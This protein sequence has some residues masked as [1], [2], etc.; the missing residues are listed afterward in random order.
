MKDTDIFLKVNKNYFGLNLKSIDILMIAQIEEFRRNNCECYVTNEQFSTMFGESESTIKR[1]IDKLEKLNII[2]RSTKFINGNGKGTKQ[3]ILSINER[4]FWKVQNELTNKCKVQIQEMEGS[5][6]DDGRFKNQEWKVHND[7]IKEK[8]KENKKKTLKENSEEIAN[9][10][11]ETKRELK[12]LD[13]SD[14]YEIIRKLKERINYIDIQKEYNLQ[15]RVTKNTANEAQSII[16]NRNYILEQEAE[17]ER[18]KNEPYINHNALAKANE[19]TKEELEAERIVQEAIKEFYNDLSEEPCE[20]IDYDKPSE[21]LQMLERM[22][23][24]AEAD[25]IW[26]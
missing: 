25:D 21:A 5:K 10:Q 3:R 1:V 26:A 13:S 17:W 16:N 9:A 11:R 2:Q 20:E 24:E 15:E 19:K 7:P 6:V 12:D 18:R 22:R 23:K 8:E 14:L 4:N